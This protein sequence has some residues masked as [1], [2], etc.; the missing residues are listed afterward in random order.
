MAASTLRRNREFLLLQFSQLVSSGGSQI[1]AIA[2]PLLVLSLTGSSAKAGIVA[3]AR[4]VPVALLSLPAGVAA[5]RLNRR[6]LMIA[7]HV[8][9]ALAVGTLAV[10]V[11]TDRAVFWEIPVVAFAEG[12]GAALYAAAQ[13]GALRAVVPREQLPAAVNVVT[14]R[15]AVLRLATPPIGGALF[16]IARALPFVVHAL[17]Y[18]ASTVLLLAMRT[19]F[20]EERGTD[21]AS[22]RSQ[23]AEGFRFLWSQPFLRTMA[24][25]FGLTN[26]IGPGVMLA[27]VVIGQ[28]DG[29]TGGAIGLLVSAF[30]A[31]VLV[32]SLV[33][34]FLRKRLSVRGILLLELWT[35]VG[36]GLFLVWPSVYV[37]AASVLPTGLAIPSTDSVVRSY[38][39]SLTPDRLLGRV[40]GVRA[41]IAL[42]IAPLGPLAAGYL[43]DVTSERATIAVFTTVGLILALWGTFSR[44][45][46]AAP[47][48]S[49]LVAAEPALADARE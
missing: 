35:W 26:F 9:R 30:G 49:G 38:E 39:L 44:G 15:E 16:G 11:A 32:G 18:V 2:Y 42:T 29:L 12:C 33:S 34:P 47:R 37:L 21:P 14:G 13:G 3:F 28:N 36:C 6:W 7:A 23:L 43:L 27:I 10:L 4:L 17:S 24:F 22:L 1:T 25:L 46:R 5:D 20:Q 8:L 41:T 19:P 48:L 40:D 31:S 45:I